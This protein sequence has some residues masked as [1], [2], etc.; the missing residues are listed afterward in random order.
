LQAQAK[1]P[2][3]KI[4]YYSADHAALHIALSLVPHESSGDLSHQIELPMP[5]GRLASFVIVESPVM[6][7]ALAARYPEIKTFKVYGID[8]P[9]ASGRVDITP[10][11]FHAMLFTEKGRLLIDPD[12]ASL[13]S[14]QYLSRYRGS[15][16]SRQFSCGVHKLDIEDEPAP[17]VSARSAARIPGKLLEYELAVAATA[18]YVVALGGTVAQAQAG[19]VTAI[20]RVNAIYERDLGIRLMLVGNNNQLIESGGNVNFS[21]NNTFALLEEN[22]T[23]IDSEIGSADYDIGHVFSTGGGGAAFLGAACNDPIKAKG[24]SGQGAPFGDPFYIDYVAHEIGHQ[25]NA[26]HSFNGTT[27]SCGGGRIDFSA[28]EP[29]SGSTVMAYA[30]ICGSESLQMNSDATFHAGSIAQIGSFTNSP[31]GSCFNTI[32]TEPRVNN[33]DP[34][35]MAIDNK[36]IPANTPFV[37]NGTATDPDTTPPLDTLTYQ[38]DQM[39]AGCPTDSSSFGT[40]NGSNA[41]FRSY[42]PRGDSWRNFPA[43]GTQVQ[44]GYDKAEVLPCQNRD[45][46]FRLT[47]RDGNSGQDTEDVKISVDNSAGPFKITSL[48]PP[49]PSPITPGIA[50]EVNWEIASTNLPPINCLSVDF[51][52]I[53]FSN[54][55]TRYYIE[56]LNANSNDNDGTDLVTL[57]NP[58]SENYSRSRVRVKCSDNIFYDLSDTDLTVAATTPNPPAI[59]FATY[60]PGNMFI[61]GS[62][63][64]ACGP[65]VDCTPTTTADSGG[66]S[67]GSGAFGYLWLLMMT[68]LFGLVKL[69]RRYGLQ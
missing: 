2:G 22:Q 11:G 33:Q 36:T 57:A 48:N 50:F 43:L 19:I 68:G 6:K 16:P 56:P 21:N 58:V 59:D 12:S 37:L 20:N 64:P 27:N 61:T 29:G 10:Q 30:G 18:E 13:Q 24:V 1:S 15:Q 66:K 60:F 41:L 42:L 46:N 25:F 32:P 45:L 44:A 52:L 67:G 55:Y 31:A 39:D 49:A 53:N 65:V 9:T 8:D 3:E 14:S 69:H 17:M 34:A 23:W 26:E 47:A 5:D 40:D 7:P 62:V 38:W 28:F 35:I 54:D 63:A 51:E 4:H